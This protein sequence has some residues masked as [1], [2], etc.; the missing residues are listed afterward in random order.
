MHDPIYRL[1]VTWQ[2]VAYNQPAHTGFFLGHGMKA[3]P[4]PNIVAAPQP[5]K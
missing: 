1:G 3:P 4:R 2:N 5:A